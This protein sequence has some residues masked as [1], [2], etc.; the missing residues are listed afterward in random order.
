MIELDD[1]S[2]YRAMMQIGM[3]FPPYI[4]RMMLSS[5]ARRFVERKAINQKIVKDL[6]QD[7]DQTENLSS[8]VASALIIWGAADKV[9]HVDN[10]AFLHQRLANSRKIV[11]EGIGHVPMVE[12][13]KQVAAACRSFY[14]E[15]AR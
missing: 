10:A 8:I 15:L 5:L 1:A 6:E 3:N 14:A 2:G 13:P 4:P 11:M 7:I 12:D 9:E